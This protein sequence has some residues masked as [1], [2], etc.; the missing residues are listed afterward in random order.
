MKFEKG[1]WEE[2]RGKNER[3]RKREKKK[4]EINIPRVAVDSHRAV[5]VCGHVHSLGDG[6]Q[7]R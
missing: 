4:E 1:D 5:G 3:K 7:V 2:R 6:P